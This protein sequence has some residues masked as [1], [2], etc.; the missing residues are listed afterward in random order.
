MQQV[1]ES[2]EQATVS[3]WELEVLN[4]SS[5]AL[6][7]PLILS[8]Y[9]LIRD[10]IQELRVTH[11]TFS[12][13]ARRQMEGLRLELV[14]ANNNLKDAKEYIAVAQQQRR[15]WLTGRSTSSLSSIAE[16][17]RCIHLNRRLVWMPIW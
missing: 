6:F 13:D 1:E 17:G 2:R 9:P 4:L 12:Q 7:L 8:M 10:L 11:T 3:Q 14:M 15:M 16:Y 5:I